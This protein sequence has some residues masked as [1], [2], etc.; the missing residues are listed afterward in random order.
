MAVQPGDVIEGCSTRGESASPSV[1]RSQTRRTPAPRMHILRSGASAT[2][3]MS[4]YRH[5]PGSRHGRGRATARAHRSARGCH[6][7]RGLRAS[8]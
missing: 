4:P 7:T 6:R 8:V 5:S 2:A 3:S 1:W